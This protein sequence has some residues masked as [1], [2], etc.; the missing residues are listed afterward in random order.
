MIFVKFELEGQGMKRTIYYLG[1]AIASLG[2]DYS[3]AIECPKFPEQVKK[4]WEVKV[5]AEVI[6][7]GPLKG[8]QLKTTTTNITRNLLAKMPESEKV[9]LEQ[10][11]LA[12]YCST[13]KDDKTLSESERSKRLNEYIGEVRRTMYKV[14]VTVIYKSL[15]KKEREILFRQLENNQQLIDSLTREVKAKYLDLETSKAEIQKWAIKYEDLKLK[16]SKLS[17]KDKSEA[18]AALIEG[19]LKKAESFATLRG[20]TISGGVSMR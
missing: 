4:D 3:F 6:K 2:L 19:D 20:V 9:Y 18:K 1:L 16:I 12:T 8:L 11:M 17:E 5:N 13:L 10:M 7:L 14:D 15:P